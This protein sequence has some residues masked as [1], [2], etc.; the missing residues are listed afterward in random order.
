MKYKVIKESENFGREVVY[1]TDDREDAE[2]SLIDCIACTISNFDEYSCDD[3]DEIQYQ[4]FEGYGNGII[5]IE[6]N[7]DKPF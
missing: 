3:I 5:Y 4:G 6:D 7:G 1:E 2:T